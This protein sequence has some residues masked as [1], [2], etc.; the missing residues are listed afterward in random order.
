[1]RRASLFAAHRAAFTQLLRL[2]PLDFCLEVDFSIL[3]V[4]IS[5]FDSCR[6]KKFLPPGT[7]RG[8]S[9]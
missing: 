4:E 1:M 8:A 6:K 5:D 7:K 9:L 2:L 3:D